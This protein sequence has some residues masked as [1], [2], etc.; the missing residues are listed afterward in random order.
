MLLKGNLVKKHLSYLLIILGV[1]I[2]L[3]S[4]AGENKATS[5]ELRNMVFN[6]NPKDVGLSKEGLG[7][8]VW[9]IVM[10]TGFPDG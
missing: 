6:L 4:E 2:S 8:H 5:E 9:G 7:F 10:E 1:M 3:M